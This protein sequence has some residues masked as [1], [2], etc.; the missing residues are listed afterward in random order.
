MKVKYSM[1]YILNI[2]RTKK[3][4]FSN[5]FSDETD[6]ET[7]A[8][9]LSNMSLE[10]SHFCRCMYSDTSTLLPLVSSYRFIKKDEYD[11]LTKSDDEHREL[12]G[13]YL[14]MLIRLQHLE[15]KEIQLMIDNKQLKI[16][17]NN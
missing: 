15:Q 10:S 11:R 4:C 16:E 17:N 12:K 14:E 2:F 7:V 3:A 5:G 1:D 13:K 6:Q 9:I 8:M